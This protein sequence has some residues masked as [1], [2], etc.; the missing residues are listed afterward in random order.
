VRQFTA[1]SALPSLGAPYF[2]VLGGAC[3]MSAISCAF[4][5]GRLLARYASVASFSLGYAPEGASKDTLKEGSFSASRFQVRSCYSE[6]K[7]K[8]A[9]FA[10]LAFLGRRSSVGSKTA[11]PN[12][13]INPT[14]GYGLSRSRKCASAAASYLQR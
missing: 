8:V 10:S 4:W 6:G 9:C 11:P 5:Q 7:T 12:K 3:S 14:A 2:L 13:S 1:F